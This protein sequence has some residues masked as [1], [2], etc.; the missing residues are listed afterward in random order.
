MVGVARVTLCQKMITM[1]GWRG[2]VHA[3]FRVHD[4]AMRAA[5][6]L[7]SPRAL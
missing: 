3:R 5:V 6:E 7:A 4:T 1:D 2:G